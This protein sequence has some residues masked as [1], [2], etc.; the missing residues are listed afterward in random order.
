MF[1]YKMKNYALL[2]SDGGM[3]IKGA[4]LKSR[5]MERY[6]RRFLEEMIRLKL[7]GKDSEIKA[8]KESYANAIVEHRIALADLAK[9]VTL[10]DSPAT[11]AA[12]AGNKA[13]GRDAAYELALK[14][15]R[16]YRAGDQLSFY[17]T[18]SRKSVAAHENSRLV[19]NADPA[20]R[21]ENTAYYVAKLDAL[22]GKF[23]DESCSGGEDDGPMLQLED[24]Q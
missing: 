21:D 1:S 12:K 23:Y 5:G 14:S 11:Y 7:E 3:V 13:R 24:A 19:S 16:E 4:A 15:G 8:L 6:L 22:Y 20:V 10:Q 9:T 18:G 2:G 17:V